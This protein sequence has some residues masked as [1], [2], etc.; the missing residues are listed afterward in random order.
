M[1]GA[2]SLAA[3]LAAGGDRPRGDR[4]RGRTARRGRRGPRKEALLTSPVDELPNS[5]F[6]LEKVYLYIQAKPP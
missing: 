5:P 2:F 3:S 6:G 1:S 4:G